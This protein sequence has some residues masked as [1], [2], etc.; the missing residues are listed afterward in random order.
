MLVNILP[1]NSYGGGLLTEV[2]EL[3]YW[4]ALDDWCDYMC[5]RRLVW[6][7]V[8]KMI[9]VVICFKMIGVVICA[10]DDWYGYMFQDD[11]YG[12]MCPR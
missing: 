1:H 5:P 9:G 7:Y 8:P 12:Y 3:V 11:W 6:L 2:N 4:C 10:Q